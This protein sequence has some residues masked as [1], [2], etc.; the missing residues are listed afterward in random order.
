V[1]QNLALVEVDEPLLIWPNLMNVDMIEAG[2][3]VLPL[4]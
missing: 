2:I 1:R 4:L 3:D